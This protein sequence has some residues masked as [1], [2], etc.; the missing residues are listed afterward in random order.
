MFRVEAVT[1]TRLTS[2][3]GEGPSKA[4]GTWSQR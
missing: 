3:A 2:P 4:A 1:L